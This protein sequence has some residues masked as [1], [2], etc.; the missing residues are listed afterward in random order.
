[1]THF[2]YERFRIFARKDLIMILTAT[3]ADKVLISVPKT[4][5]SAG[6]ILLPVKANLDEKNSALRGVVLSLHPKFKGEVHEGDHVAFI[7]PKFWAPID[8]EDD[9]VYTVHYEDI[10]AILD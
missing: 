1:M 4:Q 2:L 5:K 3:R 7:R 10:L 8:R 9:Q 6:G